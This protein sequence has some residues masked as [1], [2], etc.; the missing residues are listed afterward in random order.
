MTR[1][2]LVCATLKS[3]KEG[4]NVRVSDTYFDSSIVREVHIRASD[5]NYSI[6]VTPGRTYKIVSVRDSADMPVASLLGDD[7]Q[8]TE[9]DL[10]WLRRPEYKSK[11]AGQEWWKAGAK[12][13]IVYYK[14][15]AC[16]T[17]G[18]NMYPLKSA[19][20]A[21]GEKISPVT[22]VWSSS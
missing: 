13:R 8:P 7:G 14:G 11:L 19:C 22:L 16:L 4:D 9:F 5:E 20:L 2:K 12:S 21:D 17:D 1:P 6:R 15:G 3:A 10:R 18:E